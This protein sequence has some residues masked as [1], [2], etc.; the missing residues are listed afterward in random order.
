MPALLL[1]LVFMKPLLSWT[2]CVR[3]V[4]VTVARFKSHCEHLRISCPY[5]A[6]KS[7]A[8]NSFYSSAIGFSGW[9]VFLI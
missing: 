1:A 3:T 6:Q 9:R 4:R 5:D 2:V 7:G 8:T